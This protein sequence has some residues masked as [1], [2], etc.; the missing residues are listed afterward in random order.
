M[1]K[2]NKQTNIKWM[3]SLF[4]MREEGQLFFKALLGQKQLI[5]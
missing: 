1:N 4:I 5:D 2:K 3:Y